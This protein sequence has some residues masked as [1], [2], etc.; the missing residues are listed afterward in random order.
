MAAFLSGLADDGYADGRNV[1]IKSIAA[2]NDFAQLPVL[3]AALMK[4]HPAVIVVPSGLTTSPGVINATGTVPI[5]FLTGA[6]P[7]GLGLVPS[8][9]RPGGKLTGVLNLSVALVGKQLELLN[10]V[11][12]GV[13]PLAVLVDSRLADDTAAAGRKAA[14]TLRREFLSPMLQAPPVSNLL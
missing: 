10:E 13:A 14:A 11:C 3:A 1:V 5:V 2:N 6:D 12:P 9:N 8:L 4:D 7:V